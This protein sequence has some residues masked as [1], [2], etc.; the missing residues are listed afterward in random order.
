MLRMSVAAALA[1]VFLAGSLT[2]SSHA[3]AQSS[4]YAQGSSKDPAVCT[5]NCKKEYDSCLAQLGTQEMCG[6]DQKLC[7]K[8][9]EAR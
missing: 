1:A 5:A 4:A 7:S 8:Q 6:L 9:C 3:N 2:I